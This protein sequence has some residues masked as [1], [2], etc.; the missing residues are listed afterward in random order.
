MFV[1]G[2]ALA[3]S[4]IGGP[5]PAGAAPGLQLLYILPSFPRTIP[6]RST[7]D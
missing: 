2:F 7:S 4:A 3:F 5:R 1:V 6:A